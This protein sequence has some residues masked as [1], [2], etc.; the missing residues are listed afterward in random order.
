MPKRTIVDPEWEVRRQQYLSDYAKL[1]PAQQAEHA[2]VVL[3][4]IARALTASR[5]VVSTGCALGDHGLQL[6]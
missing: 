1:H 6:N 3:I 5:V 2:S 4:E